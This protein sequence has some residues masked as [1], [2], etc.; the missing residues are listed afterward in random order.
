MLS[1]P[2]TDERLD[3]LDG[4]KINTSLNLKSEHWQVEL[5]EASKSLTSFTMEL[6]GFYECVHMLFGLTN[7]PATFQY[8][9]KTYL[10]DLHLNWCILYP[11]DLIIFC[12]MPKEH[13]THVQGV[14]EKLTKAGLKLKPSK[15][16][17]FKDS[18]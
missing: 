8:L 17:S 15:C 11:D 5:D 1:L 9:M 16:E 10:G 6:L 4:S 3:C 13:V 14:F 18:L 2:H 12:R 7:V